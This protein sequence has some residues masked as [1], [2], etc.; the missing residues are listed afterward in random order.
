MLLASAVVFTG[1]A[2]APDM[3]GASEVQLHELL[4]NR[5]KRQQRQRA[6]RPQ[7]RQ[8]A[9]PRRSTRQRQ[10]APRRNTA[11]RSVRR[12]SGPQYYTYAAPAITTVT[13][14]SLLPDVT[15]TGAIENAGT[16]LPP[17]PVLEDDRFVQALDFAPDQN[18]AIEPSIADAVRRHYAENPA[19]VWVSGMNPNAGGQAVAE[20]I[21]N[22]AA[23]GLDAAHYAIDL[24][25]AGWSPDD[26][27][28]RYRDL[29]AF[30]L[31]LTAHALRYAMDMKDGAVDPNKLSGYHD[32][33]KDRL[34]ADA[35]LTGLMTADDPAAWLESLTPR[36]PDYRRLMDELATLR[37]ST[38]D[39]IVIPEGTFLR[40][41]AVSDAL[42][43]VMAAAAE[44]M[45]AETR[46]K[47]AAII[48]A[49]SGTTLYDG[50]LVELM[51][52]VQR[53]LELVPDGIVGPRT[54]AELDGESLAT[55]I[56]RVE[57]ALERLRWHPEEY[58]SRQVVINQPEY[59]V[60]YMEDGETKLA[61]RTVVGKRSNQTYF[62]HDEIEH[63]VY[64]PYWGVPQSI[65]VNEMLPKLR[66]DP[67]YLDRNGYVVTSASGRQIASSSINWY[68]FS[69]SVPYN[70]RQKPGPRNALGELKI[71]FPNSHAIYMHDTPSKGLFARDNRAFSHGCVRLEDPRAMAAAVL[72]KSREHVAAQLGGYEQ[73]EKLEETVPVYVG[74]F[75]AWP[76]DDGV[77]DYH[78]DVYDRDT[79][80]RRALDTVGK[81]RAG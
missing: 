21:N 11:Q 19:F 40:P 33:S 50:A 53:D 77:V 26:P 66:R 36:Q 17:L 3:A 51:R 55:K 42:P 14:L 32:F 8:Q 47:H 43:M 18:L 63:V 62:F 44:K 71:M 72:G 22:A 65:I 37:T 56:G 52:D 54:V 74:Y 79:H 69:G 12:I 2:A 25:S 6:T 48:N 35:A 76:D 30:E 73:V 38:E 78:A 23:H 39:A 68:Q 57:L 13:L 9:A 46:D 15:T 7:V 58:G 81:A 31:E 67:S 80:L 28:S 24:P 45:S 49:Y 16:G 64:D 20:L 75:T 1:W 59:R 41:G 27:A 10:A 4:F 5:A 70:V 60:R 61:M 34:T 29:I